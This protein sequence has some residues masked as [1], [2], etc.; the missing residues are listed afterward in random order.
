MQEPTQG[1]QAVPVQLKPLVQE[2]DG[3][4]WPL[5]GGFDGPG[6]NSISLYISS[7]GA[8]GHVSPEELDLEDDPGGARHHLREQGDVQCGVRGHVE[9]RRGHVRSDGEAG[10]VQ[11][12]PGG[13]EADAQGGAK[14]LRRD[15]TD[16]AEPVEEPKVK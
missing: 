1:L 15:R 4:L 2:H 13:Q 16:P 10:L 8:P 12:D 14:G 11:R 5:D 9:R 6:N 7:P 3:T